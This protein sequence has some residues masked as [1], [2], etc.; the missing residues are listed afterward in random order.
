[1]SRGRATGLYELRL[2]VTTQ[3]LFTLGLLFVRETQLQTGE[4]ACGSKQAQ[5]Q[6][7]VL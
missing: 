6:D 1:M 3:V 5:A 7:C 4:L 2:A